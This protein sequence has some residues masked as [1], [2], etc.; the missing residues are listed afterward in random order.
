MST[1]DAFVD[2]VSVYNRP[3]NS[4]LYIIVKQ[5]TKFIKLYYSTSDQNEITAIVT[6]RGLL[7]FKVTMN[8]N[9]TSTYKYKVV[10][11]FDVQSFTVINENEFTDDILTIIE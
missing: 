11:Y 1:L 3:E 5:G 2:N 7:R 8:K 10:P 6:H 4:L 9:I